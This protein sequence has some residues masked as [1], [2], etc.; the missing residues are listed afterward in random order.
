L[1]PLAG[2]T[3]NDDDP[4]SWLAEAEDFIRSKLKDGPV[5]LRP[6]NGSCT[7]PRRESD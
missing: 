3:I 5:I 1:E 6:R 2:G 7:K 4:K